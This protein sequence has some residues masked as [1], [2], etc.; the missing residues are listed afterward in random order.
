MGEYFE[1]EYTT[2]LAQE[3]AKSAPSGPTTKPCDI[4]KKIFKKAFFHQP[5]KVQ[6]CSFCY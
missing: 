5:G 2:Q 4:V 1:T 3:F 6:F